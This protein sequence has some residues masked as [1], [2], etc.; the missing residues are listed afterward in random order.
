MRLLLRLGGWLLTPLLAWAASFFGALAGSLVGGTLGDPYLGIG[1]TAVSGLGVGIL[2][3]VLWLRLLR[4]SPGIQQALHVRPDG[5]PREL[6]L[7]EGDD[8]AAPA[9]PAAPGSARR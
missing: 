9:T 5:T 2:V 1:L 7:D 4:R 8:T 3:I 6:P